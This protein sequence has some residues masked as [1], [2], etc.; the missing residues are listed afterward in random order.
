MP[1]L[2]GQIDPDF[3]SPFIPNLMHKQVDLSHLDPNFREQVYNLIRE[4]WLVFDERGV[5]VP[6]KNF[7]CVIDTGTAQPIAVKKILFGAQET[8]IMQRCISAL[9]KVGHIS[10]I[11]D[12]NWLFK[13]FLAAKTIKSM[14][15][16]LTTSS[17]TFCV[18]YIPLKGITCIVAYPIPCCDSAVCKKFGLRTWMWMFDLP[19]GT[20]NLLYFQ[21]VMRSLH[22]KRSVPLNGPTLLCLLDLPTGQQLS[23]ISSMTS[24]AFGRSLPN[25]MAYQSM[26][27]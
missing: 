2:D 10:K 14:Y 15:K 13:A 19:R 20:I 18:N 3:N 12:G 4:Y 5:F 26:M 17:G 1:N 7:K 23:S 22:F 24:T 8:I 11:M 16:I 6:V 21:R 25:R 27:I 9:A